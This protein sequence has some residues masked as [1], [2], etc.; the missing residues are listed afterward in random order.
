M[1]TP[2]ARIDPGSEAN[3]RRARVRRW[4]AIGSIPV[5]VAAVVIVA[6]LLSMFAFAHQA[7]TTHVAGNAAGTV[8]ASEPLA[9]L[10]WFEPFKAH[11]NVGVGLAAAG[12]LEAARQELEKA[13]ELASGLEVCAVQLNLGLVVEW[14]GDAAVADGDGATALALYREALAITIET[15]AECRTPEADE[16]SPDPGRSLEETLDQQEQR[17][18]DKIDQLQQQPEPQP[19]SPE[20][21]DPEDEPQPS[22]SDLEQI[23]DLLQDGQEERDEIGQQD[24][25]GGGGGTDRPW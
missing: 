13:L 8:S 3:R 23:E 14:M 7:I 1:S 15:P 19:D 16:Q 25:P 9:L 24:E 11:Y 18:R 10:N 22:D 2:T 6:K 21:E 5:L 17:I 12:E 4:I 20:P